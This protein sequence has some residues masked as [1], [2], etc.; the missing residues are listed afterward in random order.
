TLRSV[1]A[2]WCDPV[3]RGIVAS[4]NRPSGNLTGIT[5]LADEVGPKRLELLH[6]VAANSYDF[7]LLVNPTNENA[8]ILQRAMDAAARSL[9]VSIHLLRPSTYHDVE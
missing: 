5:V 7:G 6:E 9:G 4:L 2:L 3:A 1:L 8:E